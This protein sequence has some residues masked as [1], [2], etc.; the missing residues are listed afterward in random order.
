MISKIYFSLEVV[1]LENYFVRPDTVDRIRA[2]W[3]GEPIE[4]YVQWLEENGYSPKNVSRRVPLL[5]HFGAFALTR[6]ATKYSDLPDYV[7]VFV[8]SWGRDRGKNCKTKHALSKV[9]GE[10]RNPIEQMLRCILPAYTGRGRLHRPLPFCSQVP[11]FF[12]YLREERGLRPAS[13]HHYRHN[14]G[15]FE[16]YLR[17]VELHKLSGLSPEL[18]SNFVADRSGLLSKSSQTGLCVCLR[19][20]LQYLYREKL[21]SRNLSGCVESP[22]SYRCAHIP[23][24]ISWDDVGKTLQAVDRRTPTGK[25]D[26]AVLLL[27]ATYGLRGVEVAE[28]K[29]EHIDWKR[30]RLLVPERKAGH[31]TAYPLSPVVGNAILEY[32]QNGRPKG[33]GRHVFYRHLAPQRPMGAA[34]VSARAA[35]YLQKADIRIVRPG[36]HTLRHSCVQRLVDS[37][38]PLKIIGDYV[39]H[40][41]PSSTEV[42]T[43][44]Q[45]EPLRQ[46]ALGDGEDVL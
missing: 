40:R 26:Y 46:I 7:A 32:L 28:L 38:F 1:M 42:Y 34:A 36:S 17:S 5:M 24:S 27:L 2:S 20:F 14:L 45:I 25:R 35:H 30:N 6:G 22:R 19:V 44:I 18:I 12:P 16:E 3:I 21:I 15:R 33:A 31:C 10:V 37:D 9:E 29:L 41:S 11:G 43:K 8:E 39:G 23:R 13:I 4:K